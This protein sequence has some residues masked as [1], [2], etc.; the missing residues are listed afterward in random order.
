MKNKGPMHYKQWITSIK[1]SFITNTG[2]SE[3]INLN[4][5]QQILPWKQIALQNTNAKGF[6]MWISGPRIEEETEALVPFNK[7]QEDD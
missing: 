5:T 7:K 3:L 1:S 4:G 2:V 6:K